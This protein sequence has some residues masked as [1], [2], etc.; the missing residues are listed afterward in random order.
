MRSCSICKV[1][2]PLDQFIKSDRRKSGYKNE[3]KDC[4]KK[5]SAEWIKNNPE[6]YEE[7][8]RKYKLDNRELINLRG[9]MRNR[10]LKLETL[11]AYCDGEIKCACLGC[12]ETSVSFLTIDHS[13]GDGKY[14]RVGKRGGSSVYRK[15]KKDGFPKDRGLQVLCFNCNCAKG[16]FGVCPH[17]VPFEEVTSEISKKIKQLKPK[18]VGKIESE[19]LMRLPEFN[20]EW[21]TM[22]SM[23]E[24]IWGQKPL[25]K[26]NSWLLMNMMV[27]KGVVEKKILSAV[28]VVYREIR[29]NE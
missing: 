26:Q 3:C 6:K 19:F 1:Q 4:S 27:K 17:L 13:N 7:R 11:Q 29:P 9:I 10:K 22:K 8:K 28:S 5:Q 21:F 23:V 2:K 12:K 25:T 15:L 16:Q 18:R 24:K 14:D 20:G